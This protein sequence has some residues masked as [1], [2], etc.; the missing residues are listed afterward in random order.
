MRLFQWIAG[1]L[2]RFQNE[3]ATARLP[4]LPGHPRGGPTPKI[5][6]PLTSASYEAFSPLTLNPALLSC[7]QYHSKK[8]ESLLIASAESSNPIHLGNLQKVWGLKGLCMPQSFGELPTECGLLWPGSAES[9]RCKSCG[10]LVSQ[11]STMAA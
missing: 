7:R 5:R 4:P 8:L 11:S 9:E 10:S 3:R 1:T 2:L 6:P